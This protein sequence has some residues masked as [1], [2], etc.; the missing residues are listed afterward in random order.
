MS[1]SRLTA[2]LAGGSAELTLALANLNF[3]VSLIKMEAPEEYRPVETALSKQT[4]AAAEYGEIQACARKL[5][6]LFSPMLP[7]IPSLQTAYGSRASEIAIKSPVES[8]EAISLGP[9]ADHVGIDGGS[10]WAAA[11][12]GQGSVAVHLLA[13]MLVRMCTAAEATSIWKEM[14]I[15]RKE[16]ILRHEASGGIDPRNVF[17]V[18]AAKTPLTRQDLEMWDGSARAGL[19]A[20]DQAM[21][22]KQ[23]QLLLII[24]N[25][26]LS[27]NHHNNT[28]TN[29][30]Q[31]WIKAMVTMDKLIEG[32][33]H[34]LV[35]GAILVDILAWHLY[36]DMMVL[37]EQNTL[38]EQKDNVFK[39]GGI[40]TLGLET[41]PT[42]E[43]APQ[44]ISWSLPLTC[45]YYYG[46]PIIAEQSLIE[47]GSRLSLDQLLIVTLG[48]LFSHWMERQFEPA[49]AAR[50]V[51]SLWALVNRPP[52]L[53]VGEK[54]SS[55]SWRT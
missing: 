22:T 20:A 44:G 49:K 23:T 4:K 54:P 39:P 45:Y 37:G 10:L 28:Y 47:S 42:S 3:D 34:S 25:I 2:A 12:S 51:R 35:D 19:R 18:L 24:N 27:I 31:A 33:P 21:K 9:F 29:V 11:N 40:L 13:C 38:I 36:P 48:S 55:R 5:Q 17:T 32:I 15:F 53:K 6:A 1:I 52:R 41:M 46:K 14:V 26:N 16:G 43:P 8:S 7:Q 30:T 50:L